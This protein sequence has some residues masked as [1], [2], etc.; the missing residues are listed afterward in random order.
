V[1][2]VTESGEK[3][4]NSGKSPREEVLTFGHFRPFLTVLT[5]IPARECPECAYNPVG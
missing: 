2:K 5:I 1:Q 4:R 3:S